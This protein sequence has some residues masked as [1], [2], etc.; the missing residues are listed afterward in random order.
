MCRFSALVWIWVHMSDLVCQ[1]ISLLNGYVRGTTII[2]GISAT[3]T[4][5]DFFA[6]I[7]RVLYSVLMYGQQSRIALS[8]ILV[9]L[10]VNESHV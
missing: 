9:S 3:T 1:D 8:S 2:A 10:L 4:V 5:L 6:L 7:C